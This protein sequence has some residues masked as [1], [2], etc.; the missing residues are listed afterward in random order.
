MNKKKDVYRVGI[1]GSYGGL[2][3]GDEAI[4]QSIIEQLRASLPVEITVFS[5]NPEDTLRRHKVEH[6]LPVRNLAWNEITPEI[7]KLNLLIFGGGGILFDAEAKTFLR[8]VV[9][10]QE[11]GVPVMIYAI[12]TGPLHDPLIQKQVRICFNKAAAITVRERSAAKILEDIGVKQ[13]IYLTS[14]PAFLLKAEYLPD[15]T[16]SHEMLDGN[17]C[18]VGM[19]IREP[20]AAAP[21]INEEYYHSLLAN[22]ADF[23]IDRFEANVVF[24]PMELK[25]QD[26]QL[27]HS[28]I[29]RM[30][31][32][33][34]ASVIIGE[35]TSG[36]LLTMVGRLTFAIGMRLHFLIFAALQNVPF[37]ALPYASKVS[38]LLSTLGIQMPPLHL[39][40]AGRLISYIDTSWDK[41]HLLQRHIEHAVP[42]FQ[43]CARETNSIAVQLLKEGRFETSLVAI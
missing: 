33:Q 18:L 19:S 1:T 9:I 37:I 42:E 23:M 26:I 40:N 2:N 5:R 20:G 38:G 35:Y 28:V 10:A 14:D 7:K 39:V 21:D 36:Q 17:R 24:F 31:W 11:V 43:R 25:T 34:H 32:A 3:L 8:E 27:S 13:K 22:A 41:R 12:G 30:M 16:H 29:S 15:G 6:A 4:L